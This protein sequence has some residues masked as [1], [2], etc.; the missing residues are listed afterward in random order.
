M[1]NQSFI[2]SFHGRL[3]SVLYNSC[4]AITRDIS[5]TPKEKIDQELG[6]ESLQMSCWFGKRNLFFTI[7]K[8]DQ[9][10]YLFNGIPGKGTPYFIRNII[11]SP[12]Y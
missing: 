4:F 3:E 1:Y 11:I 5:R 2:N 6:L 10:K 7:F 9:P 12:F 8:V